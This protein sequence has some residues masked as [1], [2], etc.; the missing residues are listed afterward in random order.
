MTNQELIDF[1]KRQ[2]E[3]GLT[4][5][6]ITN[7]LLSS[8]WTLQ[9][10]EEG[11]KVIEQTLVQETESIIKKKNKK[12]VMVLVVALVFI[13]LGGVFVYYFLNNP[14]K[15]SNINGIFSGN[16]NA[17]IIK[18]DDLKVIPEEGLN[19]QSENQ[20]ELVEVDKDSK[21]LQEVGGRDTQNPVV[22]NTTNS[23]QT[24]TDKII[25][26][27]TDLN[28][29]INAANNCQK[30]TF[31][32]SVSAEVKLFN[33]GHIDSTTHW[34]I[35]G[36][37]DNNCVAKSKNIEYNLKYSEAMI[38]TL[39]EQGLTQKEISDGEKEYSEILLGLEQTCKLSS[40]KKMG[41][42][43]NKE[44][45]DVINTGDT[46][47]SSSNNV[48]TY[49]SGLVCGE[50]I[51]C[52]SLEELRI[53]EEAGVDN[54]STYEDAVFADGTNMS[55]WSLRNDFQHDI[56]SNLS[57]WVSKDCNVKMDSC[58]SFVDCVDEDFEI[59]NDFGCSALPDLSCY[60]KEGVR[61]EKL[62]SGVC[63]WKNLDVITSCL[64]E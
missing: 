42:I 9:D 46:S 14:E 41:D 64:N 32:F 61:C 15:I 55:E 13:I 5:E 50:L 47:F 43:L 52:L 16:K 31:D 18:E 8:N 24:T 63:G 45:F 25:D 49:D 6:I 36:K 33:L 26:C 3:K 7:Q 48:T 58:D 35:I 39:K 10:I 44:I 29:F 1:I 51:D 12:V 17:D 19:I 62:E 2:L 22:S 56:G 34:E 28:C 4:K 54:T 40:D 27:G 23:I 53:L 11:F 38:N 37:E 20:T 21:E 30:A 57:L 59:K 60:K